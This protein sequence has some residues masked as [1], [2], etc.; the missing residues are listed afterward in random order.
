LEQFKISEETNCRPPSRRVG[1]SFITNPLKP[2]ELVLFGGEW[3]SGQKV[4]MYNDHFIYNIEKEE[5]KR[6]TCPN[7]PGRKRAAY[8]FV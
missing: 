2:E 8:V 1:A 7:S 5:W 6:V 4:F 3:F